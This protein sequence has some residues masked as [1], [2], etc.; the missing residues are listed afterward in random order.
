ML[1]SGLIPP[2]LPGV[3][4]SFAPGEIEDETRQSKLS[5]GIEIPQPT[6]KKNCATAAALGVELPEGF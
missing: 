2:S 5:E 6:W 3:E 1:V 4:R